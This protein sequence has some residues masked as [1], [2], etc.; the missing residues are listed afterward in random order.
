MFSINKETDYAL[1]AV[2]YLSKNND[3]Y[4]S[5]TLMSHDLKISKRYLSK[6]LPKIVSV[7]IV[8]SKEGKN[9]GY[10]L[11]KNMK[12]VSLYDFLKIFEEDLDFVKCGKTGNSCSCHKHCEQK[13]FFSIYLKNEI[14]NIL[15]NKNLSEIFKN[16]PSH[17][18]LKDK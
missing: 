8:E 14:K 4:V 1:S 17:K 15:K 3:G 9:G 5:I 2:N 13:E 12:D 10:R 18:A 7:N 16:P 6:I 11:I